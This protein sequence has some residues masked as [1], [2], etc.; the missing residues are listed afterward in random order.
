MK[1]DSTLVTIRERRVRL[2][3]NWRRNYW[4][5]IY[6][7]AAVRD[8]CPW[9]ASYH[10]SIRLSV[11]Y[12]QYGIYRTGSFTSSTAT[13]TVHRLPGDFSRV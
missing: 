4:N 3:G 5:S 1:L 10:T 12:K 7:S 6:A 9:I 11:S 13:H 8:A 2:S